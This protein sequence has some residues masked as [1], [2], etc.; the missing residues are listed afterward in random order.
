MISYLYR[1]WA[2][3]QKTVDLDRPDNWIAGEHQK[4]PTY[5]GSLVGIGMDSLRRR[6]AVPD[7]ARLHYAGLL[8]GGTRHAEGLESLLKEYF[9]IP[10]QVQTFR[11]RW[12]ELPPE[13]ECRMGAS[14][15]TGML[16]VNAIA[17]TRVWDVQL[18]LRIRLGP[19]HLADFQRLLPKR[20]VVCSSCSQPLLPWGEQAELVNRASDCITARLRQLGGCPRCHYGGPQ[21]WDYEHQ[22]SRRAD[23]TV[24]P[25]RLV[26]CKK[27][28]TPFGPQELQQELKETAPEQ[29]PVRLARTPGCQQCAA[30]ETLDW[31]IISGGSFERL[32]C[33]IKSYLGDT[34]LWDLQLVLKKEDV[35]ESQLGQSGRLGQTTWIKAA[36][37]QTDA[38]DL[39]IEGY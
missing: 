28:R 25:V 37:L 27:C 21:D 30:V 22:S 29:I 26:V 9:G 20:L 38:E 31:T 32:R 23:G 11:G 6:D 39:I 24:V 14:P 2:I 3:H 34:Y 8:A 18:G 19:M 17:G 36:P 7:F 1:A 10:A 5:L 16:G 35:P 33:W 13:N 4:Y 12:I 15:A